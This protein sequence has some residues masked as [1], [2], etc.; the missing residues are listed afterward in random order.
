MLQALGS[1]YTAERFVFESLRKI[2]ASD[3]EATLLLLPFDYVQKL[4]SLLIYYLDRF[5][6]PELCVKCAVFLI[7]IHHGV[8]TSSHQYLNIVEQLRT[9]C[10]DAVEKL[11][12][13]VG[14]NLAGLK[15]IRRQIEEQNDV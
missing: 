3:L 13:N 8:L 12:N 10:M 2:P 15:L 5:Q 14:F 4:L 9:H 1:S 11:R 7:K 6:S